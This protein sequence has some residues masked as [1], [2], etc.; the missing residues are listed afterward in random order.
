MLAV[1]LVTLVGCGTLIPKKVEFFQKKVQAVPT[2]TA[3]DEEAEREAAYAA[4]LAARLT[5]E[6]AV[7][8]HSPATVIG[9][10]KTTERLTDAV[11]TSLGPPQD[12]PSL[13]S[14]DKIAARVIEN[15]ADL[16]RKIDRYA[17]KVDP[18]VGKKIE[19]TGLVRVP[20]F[21]Y[22]G[23]LIVLAFLVWTGLKIYGSINP[24]VGLGTNVV[25]RVA[26]SV[27]Q[28][29][30]SEIVSGGEAFKDYLEKSGIE[31]SAKEKVLDLFSRAH[32]ENQ[33]PNTQVLVRE[34]TK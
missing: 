4:H 2:K 18:L 8:N 6:S 27:L 22:V 20:Y 32:K 26:S 21:V 10:A 19:G 7:S 33:S 14:V 34:L 31:S 12:I 13:K 16:N 1:L 11:T 29:G 15:R 23:S 25:G 30:Y 17:A 3:S 5:V 9:P 28:K 24:V